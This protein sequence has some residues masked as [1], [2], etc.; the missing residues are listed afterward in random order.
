MALGWDGTIL[1]ITKNKI[2]KKVIPP[3]R[4]GIELK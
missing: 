2:G 4:S 3:Y 1:L